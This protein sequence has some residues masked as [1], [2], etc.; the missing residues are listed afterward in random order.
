MMND[1]CIVSIV[2]M[3]TKYDKI[4]SVDFF[5]SVFMWTSNHVS[6]RVSLWT[7]SVFNPWGAESGLKGIVMDTE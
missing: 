4:M 3:W 2:S 1:E 5:M 7:L 6:G